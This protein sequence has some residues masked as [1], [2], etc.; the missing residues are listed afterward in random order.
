[1]SQSTGPHQQCHHLVSWL[2]KELYTM[3]FASSL[4]PLDTF[5]RFWPD[6]AYLSWG[7]KPIIP[8]W[9]EINGPTFV[10][11]H[12]EPLPARWDCF[13]VLWDQRSKLP[14]LAGKSHSIDSDALNQL[15]TQLSCLSEALNTREQHGR[16]AS[17]E[18]RGK[19]EDVLYYQTLL[20]YHEG[21]TYVNCHLPHKTMP[22]KPSLIAPKIQFHCSWRKLTSRLV[23]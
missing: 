17:E 4:W 10:L 23:G 18:R 5:S 3:C 14:A 16:R 6:K 11:T 1:M 7:Y 12:T 21:F 19:S 22:D 15:I 2:K 8:T 9:I 13:S 20:I